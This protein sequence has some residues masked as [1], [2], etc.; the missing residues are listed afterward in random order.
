[1]TTIY[2]VLEQLRNVARNKRE[3]GELFERLMVSYLRTEPHYKQLF[4]NVWRWMDWPGREGRTDTGIDLVAEESLTGDIWAIQCKFYDPDHKIQKSDLD[5]FF[6]ESGKHPFR[7]RMIVVT[8]PMSKHAYEACH[9]QQIETTILDMDKLEQSTIDWG[10]FSWNRPDAL[11]VREKKELRE[12]QKEAIADVLEGFKQHDRG[13]LIMA[14]G[15]G[16]TF[17]ALKLTEKMVDRGGLVLFLV[18]SIALLSQ[19]LREWT[20][21]AEIPLRAFAVCSDTK[22][23]KGDSE[24][25]RVTDLAYPATTNAETLANQV[26]K[27]LGKKTTVIFSTYQSIDV[28]CN[29]QK[30]GMPAFDLVICDEAHRTTGVVQ[31][32]EASY[33]TKVHEEKFL[34]AKKRLYMTATPRIYADESKTKARDANVQLYSMDDETVYGPEFHRLNFSKAVELGILSDYK[35]VILAVDE[36]H[37]LRR[38]GY[39]IHDEKDQ[40]KLDDVAKIVGCWNALSKRVMPDGTSMLEDPRPMKRAVAFTTSIK[41]SKKVT[42]LF[43][44]TV[45]DYCRSLPE[46]D[47]NLLMCEVRHVDGTQNI[48]ERNANL[49]WLKEEPGENRCRILSNARCLTEGVD[50]PA[51]DAVI[52]LNPRNSQ[53]DV[54]QAIGRVMRKAK[55]KEYGYVI[56]PIA[57]SP[58]SS[59][60]EVLN[61]EPQYKV[62]WQVLNALRAHDDRFNDLINKLELNKNKPKHIEIIGVGGESE[63]WTEGDGHGVPRYEQLALNLEWIKGWRE[64]IYAK[65]VEKCGERRYWESWAKDVASIA[66]R[67]KTHI[68][69]ILENTDPKAREAQK[70]FSSF[71]KG[72]Q[73]NI[74]ESIEREE[75]IEM[76]A[77]HLVTKPVFDALFEGYSFSTHNPVAQSMQKVLDILEEHALWKETES[78]EK[79]YESVRTR[80]SGIDNAEGKQKVIVELYDK[81]FR[82]AFPKMT[83]RLGIVYTPVEVVD[84]ILKSADDVLQ[85][86]FGMRLSDEGVHILDPFTGTGTFIVRLLQSGLIRPEDLARKY[87]NEL[88]ANEIVLLAYYIAAINIEEAYHRLS[89]QDYEPF[90]G[91]VLTDTFRLGEDKDTLAETMFPENNERIIRQNRQEIRVIVGNPPYSAGQ[92]SENDNNQ[93]LKYDRL[94]QRIADTYAASSKA[95]LKKG[96]YDSYIR[97]IRWASDRIGDQG[98]IA[99]VTNGSFIDSNTTDGLRKCLAEEF[100]TIYC[101]NLRG[102]QRTSGEQSKKEG[103]KIFGSGSR[104]PIAITVLVK[105]PTKKG[106]CVIHYHDIGDYL[107]R[108]QKLEIIREAGS[109]KGLSWE[110]I[111]PNE[112]YDWINQRNEDFTKLIALGDKENREQSIFSIYSQGV[113]TSRD[114]W[115]YNFSRNALGNNMRGMIEFYNYQVDRF[116]SFRRAK[117]TMKDVNEFID[118][119]PYK[120]SWSR[121]LK[122]N[123]YHCIQ[124]QYDES[125]IVRSMYRPFCKQ[126]LYFSRSFNEMVYQ[127]PKIFPNALVKNRVICVTGVGSNKDFSVLIADSIP[128][129]HFKDTG[130]CFPLYYYEE[131]EEY[132]L[133][134]NY[135]RRDAITDWALGE[136]RRRYGEEVN[137]EDI[138][139]YVYGVLHSPEYR[140]RFAADLKKMLPRIPAVASAE[141]FWAFSKAGRELAYWHL[142]YETV[143]PWLVDEIHQGNLKTDNFYRVEKMRFG[144][145]KNGK[146]DKTTII[147]NSNII[148]SGIPLEAYNYVVNGKSA[149]EWIMDRYQVKT[150]KNSGITNDPNEWSDN[151]RYIVDLVKRIVRISMETIRIVKSLPKLDIEKAMLT[152]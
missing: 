70:A 106:T 19:T 9:D 152:R 40:V 14:C 50:V 118:T 127:I 114:S 26:N 28:I 122:Q 58:D 69:A 140:E 88:H 54:V 86:E 66:E 102:N 65:I 134:D 29:A 90:P 35:V 150:D 21:E 126:W 119:D 67:H 147:Y 151:P 47:E 31:G 137:K 52:F 39:R 130:Q 72:L 98:V 101:F 136:F 97:A 33:F 61:K 107:S 71:L 77:Q 85:E 11:P 142:N 143:E 138:F 32:D 74:N 148:L 22:V 56:L 51:L 117:L 78:L 116:K 13:K 120:I 15:T 48:I 41:N 123:L 36:K 55:G 80:A 121:A 59:P 46:D 110:V 108:E 139:Y 145:G 105:N 94:D 3:Q 75:A 2:D 111:E 68:S 53:V 92:G 42:E 84:F 103:G 8:A 141:D 79:F 149:I 104:A 133:E 87:R 34:K 132:L 12:H 44:Q 146:P 100:T 38:L 37:V 25:L 76:L 109:I 129:F 10:L 7:K 112:A 99:F 115:T 113:L 91:I 95:V 63:E 125:C 24:D 135:I 128:N 131:D 96:L 64:A 16:K 49:Q 43:E 81:F 4:S 27:E 83:D 1:M 17:T 6:T 144:K 57:A 18:P 5:S 45:E 60:E 20:A 30:A 89:G 23:G 82:T 124:Y 93:N 62:V 73:N